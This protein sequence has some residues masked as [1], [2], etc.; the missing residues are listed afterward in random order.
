MEELLHHLDQEYLQT[1][2]VHTSQQLDSS[3]RK[4]E[5][6]RNAVDSLVTDTLSGTRRRSAAFPSP[7]PPP[8]SSDS[9]TRE[10]FRN[11]TL[12]KQ[13]KRDIIDEMFSTMSSRTNRSII[14]S[15]SPTKTPH[16]QSLVTLK[17]WSPMRSPTRLSVSPRLFHAQA[18]PNFPY[19]PK[20]A[21]SPF[22]EIVDE[23]KHT[24]ILNPELIEKRKFPHKM[25]EV[26]WQFVVDKDGH[27]F[28]QAH[29]GATDP[30]SELPQDRE[31]EKKVRASHT[32]LVKPYL[33][34]LRYPLPP[35]ANQKLGEEHQGGVDVEQTEA[36]RGEWEFRIKPFGSPCASFVFGF[37][38]CSLHTNS[39]VADE[40]LHSFLV[41]Q[42]SHPS[43]A[44]EGSI[45]PTFVSTHQQ[46]PSPVIL[47]D[48]NL[49]HPPTLY[50]EYRL[51]R[52][53]KA[54]IGLLVIRL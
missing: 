8:F 42:P 29:K 22:D 30:S 40:S 53:K 10:Y 15:K 49:S 21:A 17:D 50:Q 26:P 7:S 28:D 39:P 41:K 32:Y 43:F 1:V 48:T 33:N 12:L 38:C 2:F 19:T 20:Y 3:M 54:N 24:V 13:Q 47:L 14:A 34:Y 36:I 27:L 35:D 5:N 52:T 23:Q 45:S 18:P 46:T 31:W 9:P 44:D 37:V 11:A 4:L 16:P 51:F 6:K 25:P